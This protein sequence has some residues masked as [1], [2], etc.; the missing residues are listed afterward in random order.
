M[1]KTGGNQ[2]ERCGTKTLKEMERIFHEGKLSYYIMTYN[3]D[4]AVI[5]VNYH[6]YYYYY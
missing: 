4:S 6:Y 3:Y 1:R 5:H 2:F